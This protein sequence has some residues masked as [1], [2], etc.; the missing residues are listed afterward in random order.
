MTPVRGANLWAAETTTGK[1][2]SV[3][4]DYLKQNTGFFRILLPA[5]TYT[6]HA[7]AVQSNFIGA[8]S[9]GPYAELNTDPSFQPPLYP[10]GIGGAPMTPVTLGN[11]TP[12]T[13]RIAAGCSATL[14][15]G[16]NG[17]GVVGGDCPTFPGTLQ[18]TAA[19]TTVGESAGSVTVS[20]SRING[21]DGAASVNFQ[22]LSG[23][24]TAGADFTSQAG[25]LNWA[26]GDASAKTIVV[27]IVP[28]GLIEGDEMFSIVLSSPTGAS[29]GTITTLT[30]TIID[31]DV[32]TAPGPPQNVS[33]IPGDGQVF[34]RFSAP[35]SNGGSPLT[36]YTATCGTQSAS[37]S[38]PP[39]TVAGLPNDVAVSCSVVALNAVGAGAP[40]TLVVVTPSAAAPLALVS[41]VSR[42]THGLAGTFDI[43]IDIAQTLGGSPSVEPRFGVAGHTLVFQF[44]QPANLPATASILP[45]GA[46][47]GS[48][49]AAAGNTL[50]VALS[51]VSERQRLQVTLTDVNGTAAQ[52]PV[53]IGFL[54]GDFNNTGA[55][56]ASDISAVRARQ[57]Q[58]I[59][60]S[61]A[62]F[63]VNASGAIDAADIAAVKQRS[64][65]LLP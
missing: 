33:A 53:A 44:N 65:Q 22:T 60:Q 23:T 29:L 18:F 4:S 57:S 1:V 45:P 47:M 50:T 2:Y 35:A 27:P 54:V 9:V 11:A 15:F 14:T 17:S 28:D 48:V 20:V 64:G 49:M 59:T 38:R 39:I 5:G 46:G 41:V 58:S 8:S 19:T 7:E 61:N 16:L 42:K 56:N 52:F 13:F 31:D 21:S 32:A 34:V 6:L 51:G 43:D 10:A 37:A 55:V 63:D 24:A 26:A 62:R 3:V 36:G 40:S 12:T 25:T 30:V